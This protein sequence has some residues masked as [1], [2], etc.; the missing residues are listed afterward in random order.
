M[1]E[2]VIESINKNKVIVIVRGVDTENCIKLAEALYEGGIRLM[3]IT[4]NQSD[5]SSW[6]TTARTIGDIAEKFEGRL[7]A[8][9]GTVTNTRLVEMTSEVGGK[10]IISPNTNPDVIRK[11]RELNLVSIPGAMTP[12]E[13]LS[14]YEIGG[15]FIK[16]FPSS[17]L[18]VKYVKSL[19]A[20]LSN[21]PLLATGGITMDNAKAFLD[22]GC[23]GLGVGGALAN[24]KAIA[25]GNYELIT[26]TAR[27]F[28]SSIS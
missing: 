19:V 5:P 26:A 25:E 16:L 11:T 9:A 1:R 22:A 18:G 12:T 7:F 17:D 8:G 14:A 24:K 21:V 15:D 10:Y 6:E 28:I 23:V 4:Y 20:P 13:I 3:E 27:E 2:T